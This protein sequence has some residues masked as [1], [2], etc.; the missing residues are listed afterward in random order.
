[1]SETPWANPRRGSAGRGLLCQPVLP[2]L[3]S[4][5]P[6]FLLLWSDTLWSIFGRHGMRRKL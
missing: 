1:M 6:E 4:L 3:S 2:P 5:C